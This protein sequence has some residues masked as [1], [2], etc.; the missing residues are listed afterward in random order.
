MVNRQSDNDPTDHTMGV[1][2][3]AAGNVMIVHDIN[4]PGPPFTGTWARRSN[5]GFQA[6]VWTGQA[7]A[8]PAVPQDHHPC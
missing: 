2:S 8:A 1:L 7:A 4:P 5:H 3:F 6:T